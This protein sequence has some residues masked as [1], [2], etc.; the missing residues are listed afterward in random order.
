MFTI[1]YLGGMQ[2]SGG[3][4]DKR[5]GEVGVGAKKSSVGMIQN[6]KVLCRKIQ[7]LSLC[8]LH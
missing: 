7:Q 3:E 6:T 5:E 8:Y 1:K 2:H 4:Q